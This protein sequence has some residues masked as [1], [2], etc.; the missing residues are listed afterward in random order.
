M[1]AIADALAARQ[2]EIGRA[3]A[4]RIVA[5]IPEYERAPE[6]LIDDLV[7]GATATVGL[8]ARAFAGDLQRQDLA[9]I[10]E[11]A[12]RRVHQGVDLDVFLHAYRVA[13]F[14]YWDACA[15]EATRLD[16]DRDASLQLARI[17]LD[18]MDLMTTHA[19]EGYLREESRLKAES[20]LQARDVIE[21]L[22]RGQP[23]GHTRLPAG[24]LV[25]VVGCGDDLER[26]RDAVERSVP[27]S[28]VA[29]REGELVLI[30]PSARGLE[31]V[32][33]RFG[34]SLPAQ[35]FPGVQQ[36]YR[37]ASLALSYASPA[38]PIVSLADLSAFECLLFGADATTRAVIE[39]KATLADE[40][41]ETVHAFADADLNVSRAAAA[42][43]VHPNTIRYRLQRIADGTGYDPRTFKGLVE[44]KVLSQ[45]SPL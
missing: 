20:G 41:L 22:L 17:A 12:A 31:K 34:V 37:E 27:R 13:L 40:D 42:L 3:I 19:A 24:P 43:H 45:S 38:R 5:E 15:E 33:A 9:V 25:T 32:D 8:L 29:I 26:T 18:A 14:E 30:A 23:P 4:R 35:G 6:E 28:L 39:S 21:R 2:S 36:A 16:L 7:A 1:R 10:R 11:L 44:L